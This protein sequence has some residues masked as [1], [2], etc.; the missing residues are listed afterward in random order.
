MSVIKTNAEAKLICVLCDRRGVKGFG[1]FG[2]DAGA[3]AGQY[4]CKDTTKCMG[5]GAAAARGRMRRGCWP[6]NC[7]TSSTRNYR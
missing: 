4:R 2:D 3:A 6:Q 7:P 1:Q 5:R